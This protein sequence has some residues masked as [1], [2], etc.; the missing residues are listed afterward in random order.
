M[1]RIDHEHGTMPLYM[2]ILNPLQIRQQF[3]CFQ[4]DP[5]YVYFDSAATAQIPDVALEAMHAYYKSYKANVHRGMHEKTAQAT[6]AYENARR[7]VQQFIHA[8]HASEIL[9]TKNCTE[10]L[11]LVAWCWAFKHM[12]AGDAIVLS[13]L[14]HHSNIVPWQQLQ[15][16]KNIELYWIECDEYGQLQLNQLDTY[17]SSG[18]VKLVSITGQ[19]NVLGTLPDL[20]TI[21]AAS[22]KVGAKVLIDAAQLV[23]H[24]PIDVQKL[25]CD[26][27][28]FSGHKLYGPTGIGV[29]YTK[30]TTQETMSEW[31]GGG[32]MI[33]D[34]RRETFTSANAPAK[35]EAGT[36]P[37]AQAIGLGAA[38]DWL[39][40]F[41]WKDI[42]KYEEKLM[43]YSREV[44]S[45]INGLTILGIRNSQFAIRNSSSCL[46]FT[47][48]SIHPHDLTDIGHKNIALRAGHH[49]TQPLHEFIG[50]SASTRLSLAL[51]N[52]KEEIDILREG[53]VEAMQILKK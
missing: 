34:V 29:L 2:A 48:D 9:F 18:T 47:L 32:G 33:H 25:N 1:Q 38:V 23:V 35:F 50:V 44:L 22:H 12:N 24:H 11:N 15:K 49:C 37:I 3:A 20:S 40:Q 17:L 10:A 52:T 42:Q 16:V 41:N 13:V 53:I 27:L 36:P 28:A 45:E 51:Y 19:S 26:F 4:E 30:K 39:S 31:L 7:A 8:K 14:E 46:S 21:I 5:S 43:K 6:D